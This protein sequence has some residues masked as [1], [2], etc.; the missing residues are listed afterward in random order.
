MRETGFGGEKWEEKS[1][2]EEKAR[3]TEKEKKKEERKGK[4]REKEDRRGQGWDVEGFE[5]EEEIKGGRERREIER[6]DGK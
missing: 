1:I 3:K 5:G 4:K 2:E 6:C